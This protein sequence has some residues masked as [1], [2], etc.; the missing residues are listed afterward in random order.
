MLPGTVSD[1]APVHEGQ[2]P[3]DTPA[4]VEFTTQEE[5][6]GDV[7]DRDNGE[8]LKN[9]LD[10]MLTCVD[11]VMKGDSLPID[12][13]LTGVWLNRSRQ[14]LDQC[15]LAGAVVTYKRKDLAFVEFD[16]D[17]AQCLD[18]PECLG[19]PDCDQLRL[20]GWSLAPNLLLYGH[21]FIRITI[22]VRLVV[23]DEQRPK[24][25]VKG[26]GGVDARDNSP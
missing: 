25:G 3:A 6:L 13:D 22:A 2:K 21:T 8:F 11:R 20:S 26:G 18:V 15:G 19:Q 23:A 24:G 5:V 17:I 1:C 16:V 7:E 10:P 14:D 9:R 12:G 4:E